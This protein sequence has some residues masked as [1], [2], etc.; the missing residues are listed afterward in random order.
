V[1]PSGE[2]RFFLHFPATFSNNRRT[3]PSN[4][5]IQLR[6][7]IQRPRTTRLAEPPAN[8]SHPSLT[9]EQAAA[10]AAHFYSAKEEPPPY[11]K[12]D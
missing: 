3:C 6:R 11:G 2:F 10:D 4:P 1:L 9:P 8:P 12:S 5:P 7:A